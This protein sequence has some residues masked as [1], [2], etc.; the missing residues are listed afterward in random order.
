MK[1][2]IL[3]TIE[4]RDTS[5]LLY[6]YTE[7]G[8]KSMI[9]RGVKKLQ[10]PLGPLSQR[11]LLL[12][13]DI[14]G[15]SLPTLKDAQLID[16]FAPIKEDILKS[17]VLSTVEELIYYNVHRDDAHERLFDFL[18]RY[19]DVLARTDAPVEL[20]LVFELKFLWFLGAGVYL[21]ACHVCDAKEGLHYDA[22]QGA[23][24]CDA[25][26]PGNHKLYG[27]DIYGPLRYYYYADINR[28][29]PLHPGIDTISS[30]L[31]HTDALYRMHLGFRSKAKTIAKSLL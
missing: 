6:A 22:H 27:K 24:V 25:H 13:V 1:A 28:F 29:T 19:I 23:L 11:G 31:G 8:V 9:A 2:Y 16:R 30:L 20:L 7:D 21:K 3:R 26:A 15:G 10:S 4:Y 18:M 12:E 5:R 17:T 14:G